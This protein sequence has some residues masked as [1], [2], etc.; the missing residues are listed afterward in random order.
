MNIATT[1][2]SWITSAENQAA[3]DGQ[4]STIGQL[5]VQLL[6]VCS[7]KSDPRVE[8]A[9]EQLQTAFLPSLAKDK[10]PAATGPLYAA[11]PML[12]YAAR[13][14][15]DARSPEE[16]ADRM[17]V[18]VLAGKVPG[19]QTLPFV[20]QHCNKVGLSEA[21]F[22]SK[23]DETIEG[24]GFGK[25]FAPN[26]APYVKRK[27]EDVHFPL[28]H[29]AIMSGSV[30]LLTG[31]PG[32]GK[33]SF[34]NRLL[35]RSSVGDMAG[36]R[37]AV[38]DPS[39]FRMAP[40]SIAT[41]CD[42]LASF[43]I[44]NQHVVPV[45]DDFDR[46]A[47]HIESLRAFES[48]LAP[49]FQFND[50]AAVF[51]CRSDQVPKI[52]SFSVIE[53]RRL[54]ALSEEGT[55]H[56]VV[57]RLPSILSE[58]DADPTPEHGIE[59]FA[60][61]IVG[62][63]A[64]RYGTHQFPKTALRMLEGAC[65]Q[66][67]ASGK[68]KWTLTQQEVNAFVSVDLGINPELLGGNHLE[69]HRDKLYPALKKRIFGQEH[70]V[71]AIVK[72][73]YE[74]SVAPPKEKP[75]GRFLFVGSP[76]TGKTQLCKVLAEELGY[77]AGAFYQFNMGE[78]AGEDAKNRFIGANPGYKQSME[79][80]TVF[81][82]VKESPACVILL[83][84][85]D[86]AHSSIQDI[87]L[88]FLEGRGRDA[89]GRSHRFDQAIF[90][91]TTNQGQEVIE[92]TYREAITDKVKIP[93]GEKISD[94]PKARDQIAERRRQFVEGLTSGA[95][96]DLRDMLLKR[97]VTVNESRV[98]EFVK[99]R[100]HQISRVFPANF[101]Q[102]T[103]EQSVELSGLASEYARLAESQRI[104]QY[105]SGKS[106]LDRALLDR[107]DFVFPFLPLE[108]DDLMQICEIQLQEESWEDCPETTKTMIVDLAYR[109]PERGRAV[110]RY[111]GMLKQQSPKF[112]IDLG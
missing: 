42:K 88:G 112:A 111:I 28:L 19:D 35:E 26:D 107:I 5:M 83:D 68:R 74:K 110:G 98:L 25:W 87:L 93:D 53:M 31:S 15:S 16:L 56:V 100:M 49:L 102:T 62:T 34:L 103:P 65:G 8:A 29:T 13:Y 109:E 104:I 73:L 59:R 75:R 44:Q 2:R 92:N 89:E 48:H 101:E 40:K 90:V 69:F 12:D 51:A 10:H 38:F 55:L 23:V 58:V 91:M 43:L 81:N 46:V 32:V 7:R 47:L 84:E 61:N 67:R 66:G 33:T 94:C 60:S 108:F 39:L 54:P 99:H 52:A 97:A 11:E 78:F 1:I 50:R 41:M 20:R 24:L 80:F 9:V 27:E 76:G 6:L 105:N 17:V 14:F 57:E 96:L 95:T 86:R 63:A 77:G 21:V 64:T 71:S 72:R 70:V 18:A 3:P 79:T 36:R 30:Y 22:A 45:F 85:I 106:M 4:V 37:L 82:A